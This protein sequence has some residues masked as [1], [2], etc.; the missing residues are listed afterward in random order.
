MVWTQLTQILCFASWNFRNY[1][2]TVG[3]AAWCKNQ[4]AKICP[5]AGIGHFYQ[6]EY[7]ELDRVRESTFVT[8]GVSQTYVLSYDYDRNG[9]RTSVSDHLGGR[10]DYAYDDAGRMASAALSTSSNERTRAEWTYDALGRVESLRRTS[11]AEPDVVLRTSYQFDVFDRL[12][13]LDHD[14]TD[15]EDALLATRAHFGYRY[16]GFDRLTQIVG[17]EGE[18]NYDYDAAS[19]LLETT[20]DEDVTLEDHEYDENGNRT[21]DGFVTV[22]G[23]ANRLSEDA[24]FVYSYDAEGHRTARVRKSSAP[25]DD[26][27]TDYSW[28]HRNRLTE[29]VVSNNEAEV[30]YRVRFD[31]DVNDRLIRRLVDADGD[32]EGSAVAS[33]SIHDVGRNPPTLG[34]AVDNL[35]AEVDA[36]GAIQTRYLFGP[37]IDQV[38]ATVDAENAA[39]YLVTDH[40]GSVRQV[41][42]ADGA[43]LDEIVYDAFGNITSET[44]PSERGR[45]A[46]TARP[47]EDAIALQNNR[48]RWYEAYVGQWLGEDPIQDK[49]GQANWRIY[50]GN[51]PIIGIDPNGL[52]VILQSHPVA[53][54]HSHYSLLIIPNNQQNYQRHHAFRN[55]PSVNPRWNN[56]LATT[57]GAGPS[58]W[59]NPI[60]TLTAGF[61]RDNDWE[62]LNDKKYHMLTMP[63]NYANEDEWIS[64]LFSQT[65]S[66]G[67]HLDY[68]LLPERPENRAWYWNDSS[69]N[70]NSFIATLL[71]RTHIEP[72]DW[73][74]QGFNLHHQ[75][76]DCIIPDD[77]WRKPEEP[78]PT[79]RERGTIGSGGQILR[80][81]P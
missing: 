55:L 32:G 22:D 39:R 16:D 80:Q 20:D 10:I 73:L 14:R 70:S 66:F 50:V 65:W 3:G 58:D 56:R 29:V 33:Y 24:T 7:D 11:A 46:Y 6:Y 57:I 43:I 59:W 61:R 21:D 37:G 48:A 35:Y 13:S 30:T 49:S 31:Y 15:D 54:G 53:R 45:L 25:A 40:L 12:K 8:D 71:R 76:A 74:T 67:N 77:Q 81:G 51:G 2:R 36:T 34:L 42:A 23:E 26:Y 44:D 72:G 38:L 75:G 60:C 18:R 78:T 68:D 62:Q 19:Q 9:R 1:A 17:P 63:A 4:N 41:L 79:R 64:D 5:S 47:L 27:R 69:Y 28:D 52:E